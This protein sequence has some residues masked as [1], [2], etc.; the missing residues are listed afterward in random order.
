V[1]PRQNEYLEEYAFELRDAPR[2]SKYP[3]L[4]Y[5]IHCWGR[6]AKI[7]I[8]DDVT[9]L[10][11]EVMCAFDNVHKISRGLLMFAI[12]GFCVNVRLLSGFY[13]AGIHGHGMYR[14]CGLHLAAY[15]GIDR[16]ENALFDAI[17]NI[18]IDQCLWEDITPLVIA[19]DAGHE[20][21]IHLLRERGGLKDSE[22]DTKATNYWRLTALACAAQK[23]NES[24]VRLLL[25]NFDFDLE[26]KDVYPERTA[27]A[28]A[29]TRGHKDF[30]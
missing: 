28:W 1:Q 16:I 14:F 6:H 9:E 3:F 19:A 11:V 26:Q 23:G 7:D 13:E 12:G 30:S 4:R 29:V 18:E 8:D 22:F 27:L 21:I 20:S 2:I 24:M 15:F 5:A 25:N 17:D 10:A